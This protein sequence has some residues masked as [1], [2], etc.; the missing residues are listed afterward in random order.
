MLH[1]RRALSVLLLSSAGLFLTSTPNCS[2]QSLLP[3]TTLTGTVYDP[4]GARIPHAAVSLQAP[5]SIQTSSLTRSTVTDGA[6]N[7]SLSLPPGDYQLSIAAKGFSVYI[8]PVTLASSAATVHLEPRLTIA[9]HPE[10]IAVPIEAAGGTS[11][12]SNASALVFQGSDLAAFSNDDAT[13][14]KELLALADGIS[15]KPPQIYVDGFLTTHLPPKSSI[16]SIRLNRNPYSALYD[17]F[18][19]RRVEIT[20]KPGTGKLHGQ[21]SVNAT[22]SPFN[23]LNP[24]IVG[25]APPYYILNLDGSLSG[26]ID[27][28]TSFFLSGVVNDQQNNAALNAITVA[29]GRQT[30][31]A[32]ALR[33]PQLASTFALRLDRQLSPGNTFS[34][35]YEFNQITL[36]NGGL[37]APLTLASQAFNS[38]ATTQTLRLIDTQVIGAH[39]LSEAHFQ[40]IRSRQ[41]QNA[42]SNAPTLLV[43]GAFN[44]G[45]NPAQSL[46]DNQ[47]SFEF[48]QQ[49]SLDRGSHYLRFGARYRLLREANLATANYNGQYIFPSISA[50]LANTPSLYTQTLGQSS[51][52]LLTG[53]LGAYAED[54]WRVTP[55]LTL[56]FGL[57]LESQSAIPTTSTRPLASARPGRSTAKTRKQ[58][59]SP[60]A[61]VLASSSIARRRRTSSPL[62]AR[63]ASL[64]RPTSLQTHATTPAATRWLHPATSRSRPLHPR[65]IVSAPTSRLS[66]AGSAEL[67][68]EKI[69]GRVG[70]AS[71]TYS[72]IRG[73]HQSVSRNGNAPQ[74]GTYNPAI[75]GSGVR[76]LGGSQ[77]IYE[78][79]SNAIAKTQQVILNSRLNFGRH[80]LL[81]FSYSYARQDQDTG[82]A[83]SFAS[84]SYNLTQDYGR[85]PPGHSGPCR[86][87]HRSSALRHRHEPLHPGP[88]RHP[89]QHHHRHRPQRRH[90]LQRPP[91][92]RH[93][94]QRPAL[95]LQNVPRHLR[96]QPAARRKDHPDQLRQ[97]AQPPVYGPLRQS[98]LPVWP[99]PCRKSRSSWRQTCRSSR[100]T[101]RRHLHR[102]RPQLHQPSQSR[103]A[104]RSPQLPLLR[105][106]HHPQ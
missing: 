84:N 20:T 85:A 28:K 1:L 12:D 36:T 31:Y 2:A 32:Q 9:V 97:L 49:L 66:M 90:A 45:G 60:C 27:R 106:V 83:T 35:R 56:D 58:P 37:T 82:G 104:H 41:Q 50:Y 7:F 17:T 89:L 88:W 4:S 95:S 72:A 43:Q 10:E 79:D 33:D 14:Q 26:P 74:P 96:R 42:V 75:P 63:T 68:A 59:S 91:R 23:A 101:L 69:F 73:V 25:T 77:N 61:R 5:S 11:G 99:P 13:F 78:F 105:P 21:F 3:L 55:S 54:E 64:S 18:G 93:Q 81:F 53:D 62:S 94:S 38:G 67:S 47:D 57:R 15:A 39:V 46:R 22:D 6:G 48:Q 92:L 102:R 51:F 76:P 70:S 52:S 80:G 100:P 19:N 65:P 29:N 34:S 103:P 98:Q 40:Y 87:W 44:G 8:G 71:I 24:Y 86:R 16:L 30:P